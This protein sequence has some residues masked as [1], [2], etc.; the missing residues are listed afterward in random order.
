MDQFM[1]F[2]VSPAVSAYRLVS[3]TGAVCK[4]NGQVVPCD[5]L[6]SSFKWLAGAGIGLVA[7]LFLVGILAFVFW[8]L[9]VID[10]I[11]RDIEHKPIW[12]L[13]LLLTGLIGAII[14]YFAVKR[15]ARI[16]T[17]PAMSPTPPPM[18]TINP[19]AASRRV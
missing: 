4:V 18:N 13:V 7:V 2:L 12:I 6:W 10:A 9:M 19:P 1:S 17:L 5:Q 8:L 16:G 14:Y 15:K 11:K 3:A